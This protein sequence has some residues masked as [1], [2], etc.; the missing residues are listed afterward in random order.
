MQESILFADNAAHAS[1]DMTDTGYGEAAQP[2]SDRRDFEPA[3]V[4][5]R[6]LIYFAD[7]CSEQQRIDLVSAFVLAQKADFYRD[8]ISVWQT[9]QDQL[10]RQVSVI[11]DHTTDVDLEIAEGTTLGE[12]M[13][14][15]MKACY[16]GMGNLAKDAIEL[17]EQKPSLGK[18][19]TQRGHVSPLTSYNQF[20]I[21]RPAMYQRGLELM[22]CRLHVKNPDDIQSELLQWQYKPGVVSMDIVSYTFLTERFDT[23][24]DNVES[25]IGPFDQDKLLPIWAA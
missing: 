24:R 11:K 4:C 6:T 2:V 17:L 9:K 16:Q 8:N 10:L 12:M 22:M 18:I 14:S 21:A 13:I 1:L 23:Q 15:E 5:E 19:W 7:G 20:I 25:H 3:G